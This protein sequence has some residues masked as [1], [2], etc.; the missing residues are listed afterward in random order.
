M[1]NEEYKKRYLEDVKGKNANIVNY[2]TVQFNKIEPT[3]IELGKDL[4]D[5]SVTELT[6]YY[7]SLY[8]ASLETLMVMNNQ[9]SNYISYSLQN[10]LVG[11]CLNHC[12]EIDDIILYKCINIGLAQKKIYSRGELLRIAD[13]F[14]NPYEKYI[15]LALF[16]GICGENMSDIAN[17]TEDNFRNGKVYL[18]SGKI[19]EVSK[20]LID[21]MKLAANEFTYWAHKKDESYAEYSFKD[22]DPKIIKE[23]YNS[24][25]GGSPAHDRRRV[26]DRLMKIAKANQLSGLSAKGLL[27]SGRIEMIKS[28]MKE[29]GDKDV[30]SVISRH[31][32]D[33]EYRYGKITSVPRY[34]IKYGQF[35][36]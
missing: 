33:I 30:R 4:Y 11:D 1:Y 7:K 16:E 12:T 13:N 23:M 26:Y 18:P 21:A 15:V 28:Y 20:E 27:E 24:S 17:L 31:K 2:M 25:N 10:N 6:D 3:E 22:G 14:V 32:E 35:F 5:F 19:F 9:F 29:D 8:T 36:E 34:I